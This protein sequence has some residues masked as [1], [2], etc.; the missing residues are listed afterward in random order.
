MRPHSPSR[1]KKSL[2]IRYR[3]RI[4]WFQS[5]NLVQGKLS[6]N[7]TLRANAHLICVSS[8]KYV[9]VHCYISYLLEIK[10]TLFWGQNLNKKNTN[11]I[12]KNGTLKQAPLFVLAFP[13]RVRNWNKQP[14]VYSSIYDIWHLRIPNLYLFLPFNYWS[15]DPR[16]TSKFYL[17]TVQVL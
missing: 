10:T 11:K 15:D 12:Q 6:G 8:V 16:K 2:N 7:R 9:L 4:E 13:S 1:E 14:G 17:G 5:R 3:R